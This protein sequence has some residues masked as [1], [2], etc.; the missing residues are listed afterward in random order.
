M[1][2]VAANKRFLIAAS[3]LLCV[4]LVC[5]GVKKGGTA[6]PFS[7]DEHAPI[8]TGSVVIPSPPS[9]PH[10]PA[11]V[12][13]YTTMG[14]YYDYQS[15]GTPQHI[16]VNPANGNIHVTYM[17]STDST[18]PGG[19]ARVTVYAFSS[20]GGA[21][22]NNFNN[23]AVPQRRSGFPSIDLLQGPNAGLAAIGNHS[24]VTI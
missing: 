20:D 6:K 8:P 9:A 15:N 11:L 2:E 18:N 7:P 24:V 12:G 21:T 17:T 5:A 19:N 16:R 10:G 4:G 13:T 3:L 23:L 14:G 1:K 22:W